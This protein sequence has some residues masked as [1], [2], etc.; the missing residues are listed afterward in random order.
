MAG[1]TALS[2]E[3]RTTFDL[4]LTAASAIR[5]AA[6]VLHCL[7][8]IQFH[9][10]HVLVPPREKRFGTMVAIHHPPEHQ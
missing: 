8:G 4:N 10:W 5:V 7:A 3:I 9:Q 1:L 6:F 2:V